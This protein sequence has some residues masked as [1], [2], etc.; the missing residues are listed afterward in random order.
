MEI[1][2]GKDE[3]KLV[4]V[5]PEMR[6]DSDLDKIEGRDVNELRYGRGSSMTPSSCSCSMLGIGSSAPG[7]ECSELKDWSPSYMT[8]GDGGS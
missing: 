1:S 7:N 3:T 6:R 5:T 2:E 4:V 8:D